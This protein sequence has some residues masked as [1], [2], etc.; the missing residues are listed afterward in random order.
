M[1]NT[2]VTIQVPG[3]FCDK[4]YPSQFDKFH[5][6]V[7]LNRYKTLN[8]SDQFLHLKYIFFINFICY[9]SDKL[10]QIHVLKLFE[11]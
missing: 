8:T 9:P 1:N 4:V 3:V 10:F 7:L 6:C 5:F 2:Q 11:N